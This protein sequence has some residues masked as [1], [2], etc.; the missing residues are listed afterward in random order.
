MTKGAVYNAFAGLVAELLLNDRDALAPAAV[1]QRL[2]SALGAK[3]EDI[4]LE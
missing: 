4:A 2:A 1:R 3:L